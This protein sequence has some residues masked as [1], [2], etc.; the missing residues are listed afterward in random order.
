MKGRYP[1]I[2]PAA[3][4]NC[5]VALMRSLE[6]FCLAIALLTVG[7]CSSKVSGRPELEDASATPMASEEVRIPVEGMSCAAC[8]ARLKRGLKA[9][10]GVV[11]VEVSLTPPEARVRYLA[12]KTTPEK[13]AASINGLGFK[14]GSPMPSG[15]RP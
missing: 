14:A 3:E 10:E 11:E 5:G 4:T 15:N 6:V 2:V 1:I 8:A 7:G 12:A 9:I 13:I